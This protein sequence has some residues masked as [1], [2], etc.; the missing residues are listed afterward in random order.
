ME[1]QPS[2]EPSWPTRQLSELLDLISSAPDEAGAVAV[3][4]ERVA[5]A[6]DAELA[7]VVLSGETRHAIGF[8]AESLPADSLRAVADGGRDTIE[9]AGLGAFGAAAAPISDADGEFVLVGRQRRGRFSREELTL[10]R[11]MARILAMGL[12]LHRSLAEERALRHRTEIEVKERKRAEASYRSLVER[13]PAIVYTAELGEHGRWRYVSPQIEEILGYTAQEWLADPE[14]WSKQLHPEDRERAVQQE[15]ENTLGHRDPPPI[16]Y[17]M[18]TRSGELV[19]LLDEAVL[20][21]D[22]EGIPVWHGIL[23]DITERKTAEQEVERRASQQAAVAQLGERALGGA[24]LRELMET[25][26]SVVCKVEGV[27]Q[28][29]VWELP[30]D[31]KS[32][33][34]RE[35]LDMAAIAGTRVSAT[36][37]SHAGAALDTGLHV[38][39]D[40]WTNESRFAMPPALRVLGVR[41]QP[42]GRDRRAAAAVRGP[43]RPLHRAATTS[44]PRTCTSCSRWQTCSPTRSSGGSPTTCCATASCTIAHRAAQPPPFRRHPR[45]GAAPG[46]RAR[47]IR[48][49]SSSSTSTTSR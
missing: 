5:Q 38:I 43:R 37:D 17:R 2:W 7:A 44:L 48:S 6:F 11:G 19:W 16:D 24:E 18:L 4:A 39:V 30:P 34:L 13:L 47:A 31:D 25:A 23:Y 28:A 1:P 42:R 32:L 20:E 33:R 12:Q 22:E 15:S 14:L 49:G 9:V 41:S 27:D 8:A 26:V 46:G 40:D 21:A 36:R 35:G 10:L 29:C 45:G 3:A